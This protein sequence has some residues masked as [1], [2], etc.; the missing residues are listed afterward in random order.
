M[1]KNIDC[2]KG[3]G[4]LWS[5]FTFFYMRYKKFL[6]ILFWQRYFYTDC[7]KIGKIMNR[8]DEKKIPLKFCIYIVNAREWGGISLFLAMHAGREGRWA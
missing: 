6:E 4:D 8:I 1:D 5:T 2:G 7:L 3:G